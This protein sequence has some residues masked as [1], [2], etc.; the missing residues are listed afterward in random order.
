[1]GNTY[2]EKGLQLLRRRG[3]IALDNVSK[4]SRIRGHAKFI[5]YGAGAKEDGHILFLSC[6]EVGH[7][8]LFCIAI[9]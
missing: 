1:V 8:Y 4:I 7:T 6:T 2:Y 5:L 9:A 3:F